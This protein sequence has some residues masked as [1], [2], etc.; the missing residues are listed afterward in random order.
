[1]RGYIV[2]GISTALLILLPTAGTIIAGY[3][4][5]QWTKPGGMVCG[6]Y[7][8][9]QFLVVGAAVLIGLAA[10]A[11]AG[12]LATLGLFRWANGCGLGDTCDDGPLRLGYDD[13]EG[14]SL[15]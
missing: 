15:L 1:L 5:I 3:T 4:A 2:V 8:M 10:G 13:G 14:E 6:L 7:S 11:G 9:G 12:W